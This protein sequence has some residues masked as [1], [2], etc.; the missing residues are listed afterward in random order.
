[1]KFEEKKICPKMM[2]I[3]K[4]DFFDFFKF[5]NLNFP[6]WLIKHIKNSIK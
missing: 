1:M 5:L 4:S 3:S 6:K 2:G